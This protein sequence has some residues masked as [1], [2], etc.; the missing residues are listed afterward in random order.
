MGIIQAFTGSIGGTFAD[1][2]K[3][4]ISAGEFDEHTVVA[5]GIY[6]QHNKGR[7]SNDSYSEGVIT[8]GS[9]IFVPENTAA[10]IFSQ[11]GIEDIITTSGGYEYQNGES[12]IFNGES[13]KDSIINQIGN[14]IKFGGQPD[15]IK[16]I[17]FVNLKEI[18]NIK[19]GTRGP[20]IYNDLYY[21]TDLEV[22]SYG[23]FSIQVINPEK[24]IKNFVPANVNYY[25]FDNVS[26]REQLISEFLQ[27]FIVALNS[28]S[29]K[30][31]ISQLPS[32]ATELSK[33]IVNDSFNAGSWGDRFGFKIVKVAIEN[34]EF[35][36]ESRELIKQYSSKKLDVK[37]YEDLSQKASNIAAQQK[38]AQ[39]IQEHGLNDMGGMVFGMNFAQHLDN[40]AGTNSKMS[41]DEQISNLKKLKELLDAGILTQEEFDK[42]KKEIMDL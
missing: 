18:R 8:N 38:I 2:W 32:Q 22:R 21:E 29:S 23:N 10:F 34:I 27:S 13:I 40:T 25:S 16:Y 36:D 35:T 7:G 12:S 3:D 15:D 20:V 24:F 39:G 14:R 19:F 5:P 42:K 17:N 9:K 37:A 28:L 31:R 33:T 6:K 41:L 30:Y 26:V 1:Q 11:G 4:I